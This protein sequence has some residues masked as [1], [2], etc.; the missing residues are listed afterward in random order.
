[1]SDSLKIAV[2]GD[3]N[4]TYNSHQAT[5]LAIDHAG[6]FL[7][8]EINY[9]WIKIEEAAYFK[10]QSF[11]KYDGIWLA[12]GPFR[13]IF[14]INSIL[15]TLTQLN[16]PTL[17]TG[18][19]YRGLIEILIAKHNLNRTGEKLISENLVE[20]NQF[21]SVHIVPHSAAMIQLYENHSHLELTSSRYSLYPKLIAALEDG[22]VDIEAFNQ[23]EEP[24]IIS[25]RQHPFFLAMANCPQISSTREIPHPIIYTFMKASKQINQLDGKKLA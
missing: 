13:N 10:M 12:P 21:E 22:I 7:E 5:N 1:M 16:I 18:E 14:F 3:Y 2:L 6:R 23:L 17:V 25:L 15:D 19:G 8:Q 9:Y 11:E 20:G 4:F 24:E